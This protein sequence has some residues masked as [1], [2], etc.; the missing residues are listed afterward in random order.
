MPPIDDELE[1]S[2]F[3]LSYALCVCVGDLSHGTFPWTWT[4]GK[5]REEERNI[6]NLWN[7]GKIETKKSHEFLWSNSTEFSID[8]KIENLAHDFQFA[9]FD[10]YLHVFSQR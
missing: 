10:A 9:Q 4:G 1:S 7:R 3:S 2:S 5:G 6:R 8:G